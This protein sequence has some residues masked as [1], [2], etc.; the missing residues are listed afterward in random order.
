VVNSLDGAGS[1]T[2][3]SAASTSASSSSGSTTS[4]DCSCGYVL[5]AYDSVYYPYAAIVDFSTLSDQVFSS[6]DGLKSVGFT[7]SDGWQIG[8]T[9]TDGSG[10]ICYGSPSNLAING[11]ILELTVPGGQTADGS[12]SGAEMSFST[13]VTGGVFTMDAMIDGTPG[14][15]QSIVNRPSRHR[16]SELTRPVHLPHLG[17]QLRRT[18][19]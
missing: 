3:S 11:G 7:I 18:G 16:N 2:T 12:T 10:T 19:H 17:C 13:A 14:T 6:M 15:C 1:S 4:S 8:A 9:S 5:A